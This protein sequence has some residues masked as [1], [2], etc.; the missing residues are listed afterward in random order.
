MDFMLFQLVFAIILI[1]LAVA[2][3]LFIRA[4][5]K[6]RAGKAPTLER[7]S[8]P[9]P[10]EAAPRPGP[11]RR[12]AGKA[13][14]EPEPA[15]VRRRQIGPASAAE[16]PEVPEVPEVIA[17]YPPG[18]TTADDPGPFAAETRD[19]AAHPADAPD[20]GDET[21]SDPG[22][23]EANVAGEEPAE[24]AL[25]APDEAPPADPVQIETMERLEDAFVRLQRGDITLAD[26]IALTLEQERALAQ[27]IAALE[28]DESRPTGQVE[29]IADARAAHDAASW[30]RQWAEDLE[31]EARAS[32]DGNR[33][34]L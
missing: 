32:Q 21:A 7:V 3:W 11:G 4:L 1:A 26:Y 9:P 12:K 20:A 30:C 33:D 34:D 6:R 24:D 2:G 25:P 29:A 27:R 5:R 17:E 16:V 19:D 13:A 31:A 22:I 15:R 14:A 18:A 23:A 28:S 8:S 10:V